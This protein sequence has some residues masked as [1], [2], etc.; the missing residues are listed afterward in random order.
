MNSASEGLR[1]AK[2]LSEYAALHD[3]IMH[4]PTLPAHDRRFVLIYLQWDGDGD[5]G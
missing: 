2:Y 5:T 4:D 3:R 1:I